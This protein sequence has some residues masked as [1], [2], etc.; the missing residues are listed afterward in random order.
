MS[1]C[2]SADKILYD[3]LTLKSDLETSFNR[4]PDQAVKCGFGMQGVCCRLCANGPCRITPTSPR[5]VCGA[6]PDTMVARNFLR[7]VAAGAACYLHIVENAAVNLREIGRGNT[8]LPLKGAA[9]LLEMAE[10]LG[11][12]GT[13]EKQKAANLADL[14]L[15]DLYRPRSEKMQ[16]VKKLAYG[17]RYDKWQELGILP[18]GAK[19]EVFDA[20]VKSSTNLSSDPLDMLL[21]V[22]RLGIATGLYGLAMTNRINDMIWGEPEIRTARAGFGVVDPDYI[23]IMVTG[24]QQ[25][26]VGI[27][28]DALL[29][30][31]ADTKAKACGAKGYKIVGST[32]VGQ[33]MQLRGAHCAD[34]FAGHT[35]NNFTSEALVA[36][37]AIDLL[38][39]EFNCTL[40]GI[41]TI[42]EQMQVPQF[43]LDDVAK[44][45]NAG[46][47]TFDIKDRHSI[48]GIIIQVGAESFTAR[49]KHVTITVPA[50]GYG[51]VLTGFSEK[52]LKSFLGG[53]YKPLIEL[54]A[55]GK[56][57]GIAAVVGCSNLTAGGHDVFTVGMTRELI[58]RDIIVLSAGCTSGALENVGLMS[59]SA[60]EQAGVNLKEVCLQLGIPPVLNFGPCLAIGRLEETAADI[61]AEL[62]VDL[63]QLPLV[64]SAPQW[65]EEQ[66]LADGA[67]GLAL[68]L[69]LHL[70]IPPFITGSEMVTKVLTGDLEQLTGGRVI[71]DGDIIST[72]NQL[73]AVIN[74][75][76][77][78]LG[79]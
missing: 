28:Q 5:G 56:I 52:T 51:D 39:S 25:S 70:A 38:V 26:L 18:G 71:V 59:P 37:G 7:A 74:A 45:K 73:E 34:V 17:P 13:D 54:I 60:A 24:H 42:C 15:A 23:N 68:G 41:E 2:M 20:I 49:R 40:P 48:A 8:D 64:L 10:R 77:S 46:Y 31:E 63:P 19:S 27:L 75:K 57:K 11:V 72:V 76:R 58:K 66:A 61:A 62:G 55:A 29:S 47:L 1:I 30:P 9:L 22:L 44:K 4:V 36:T 35:G 12:A 43:C 50:H 78:G 14:V 79:L 6:S 21:H 67:F 33:D 16:L 3:F 69:T 53:S 65:L 32:C